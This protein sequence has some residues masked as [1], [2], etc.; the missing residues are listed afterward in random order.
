[1]GEGRDL[2]MRLNWP[3][4]NGGDKRDVQMPPSAVKNMFIS[5][6]VSGLAFILTKTNS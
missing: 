2:G 5:L 1:M 3:M 4:P 6:I